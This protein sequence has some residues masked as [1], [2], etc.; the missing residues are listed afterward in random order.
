MIE[1][2][3]CPFCGGVGTLWS[4]DRCETAYAVCQDCGIRTIDY[5][6]L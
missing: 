6:G 2:K 3:P 4:I 1:L 5:K